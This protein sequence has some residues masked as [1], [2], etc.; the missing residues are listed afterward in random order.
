MK[1]VRYDRN[2]A[3]RLGLID[4]EHLIDVLDTCPT[5]TSPAIIAAMSDMT[6]FIASGEQGLKSAAAALASAR[7]GGAGRTALADAKLKAPLDPSLILCS[8]EN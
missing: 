1:L 2:G 6:R 3:L 5:G 4:G 7:K 8:G